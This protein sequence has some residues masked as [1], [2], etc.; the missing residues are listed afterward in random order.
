MKLLPFV[1]FIAGTFA[2]LDAIPYEFQIYKTRT[3]RLYAKWKT[4]G[5]DTPTDWNVV[6]KE[7][8][9]NRIQGKVEE[10]SDPSDS[11]RLISRL[12]PRQRY[13][14]T[15]RATNGEDEGPEAVYDAY[16]SPRPAD[17]PRVSV[18][19]QDGVNI[20]WDVPST[21]AD[22]YR[23]VNLADEN[24]VYFATTNQLYVQ[25]TPGEKKDFQVQSV[26]CG[27][28]AN[29]P[30]DAW[31]KPTYVT[32]VSIPPTP[33]NVMMSDINIENFETADAVV[34]WATPDVGKWDQVKV[35]YSPNLPPAKTD[36]PY[37]ISSFWGN[38]FTLEGLYQNTVY[39]VTVRFVSNNVEGAAETFTWGIPDA[40]TKK[41]PKVQNCQVPTYLRPEDL[42]VKRDVIGSPAMNIEWEHPRAKKPENGYRLVFAPFS[43][44]ADQKPWFENVDK[45][46]KN[47]KLSGPKYDPYE[48]YTVSLIALHDE[49]FD[50][51]HSPDFIASHF[52]GTYMKNQ[53]AKVSFVAPDACC[54]S[55]K[56]NSKTSSCCGGSLIEDGS[57]MLCC[58]DMPYS[59][60]S[61]KCCGDGRLVSSTES[62]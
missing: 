34:S 26:A 41:T 37:Y 52:T 39:T 11:S 35:E 33:I 40:S 51:P 3:S 12:K 59:M 18:A 30:N 17:N 16:T 28:C 1:S 23:V 9:G 56:H 42:R 15:I 36:T 13:S 20:E 10:Q 55:E 45:D 8:G 32:A 46:A 4:I 54:G 62:C 50:N 2:E 21:G 38:S 19:F 5:S 27:D 6:V 57:S 22:Q 47:F 14:I 58:K 60:S 61:N 53:A 24:E 29:A 49:Q 48:E 44:I 25:M 7:Y 31:G 43:H